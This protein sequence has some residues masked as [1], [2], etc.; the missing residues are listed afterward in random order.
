M[1]VSVSDEATGRAR[2]LTESRPARSP[3]R[4]TAWRSAGSACTHA[5]SIGSGGSRTA[6]APTPASR[7]GAA[8]CRRRFRASVVAPRAGHRCPGRPEREMT[9]HLHRRPQTRRRRASS[10]PNARSR[11]SWC[12]AQT[13]R[14]RAG[15]QVEQRPR[16]ADRQRERLLDVDVRAALQGRRCGLEVR[17]RRRADVDD[18][19]PRLSQQGLAPMETPGSPASAA[20]SSARSAARSCTPTT[21]EGTASRASDAQVMTGHLARADERDAEDHWIRY[22][23]M[24]GPTC[25]VT[26]SGRRRHRLTRRRRGPAAGSGCERLSR[27]P[28][29]IVYQN[30]GSPARP[31]A[32]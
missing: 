23:R 8:G 19:G 6:P 25:R 17:A 9:V 2:R 28:I 22:F 11:S 13:S 7:A 32:A 26:D 21:T 5:S 16:V 14:C 27:R 4:S 3:A 24:R 30:S 1:P 29:G 12:P 31:T 10:R 20:N 15:R 18:V